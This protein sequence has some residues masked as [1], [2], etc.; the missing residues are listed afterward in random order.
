MWRSGGARQRRHA[1]LA[2]MVAAAGGAGDY[3]DPWRRTPQVWE[4]F[5]DEGEILRELQ[6]QWRTAL[7][8]AIYCAIESGD[9]DLP[10]DVVKAWS[11]VA[12]RHPHV[13]GVLEAHRH[14]PAIAAAMAKEKSLLS[15]FRLTEAAPAAHARAA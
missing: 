12:Q 2:R 3:T 15:S 5:R 1:A 11:T 7:A 9:G 6:Q 4:H 13:R 10:G 14:H 8:G